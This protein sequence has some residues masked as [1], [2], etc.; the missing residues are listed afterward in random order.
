MTTVAGLQIIPVRPGQARPNPWNPNVMDAE[1][2]AK[3]LESIRQNG[4]IEPI[5]VR[6]APDGA[7]EIIDGFHRD[8]AAQEL[9]LAAIPAVN[10]GP[11][12]DQQAKKL[13]I[14]AN[15]LKGKA[16][17][18]KLAALVADLAQAE[19]FGKLAL[20]LP[21]SVAELDTLAATAQAFDWTVASGLGEAPSAAG[22]ARNASGGAGDATTRAKTGAEDRRFVL[23]GIQGAIPR[24]LA[25]Q[26]AAEYERSAAATG[27]KALEV[28]LADLVARLRKTAPVARKPPPASKAKAA[29]KAAPRAQRKGGGKTKAKEAS[30]DGAA[31]H[32]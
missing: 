4:F 11:I 5:T 31:D 32:A 28:V 14:I 25:D 29:Q 10:L 23:G 21:Y 9:A 18:A 22:P 30:G 13:T 15:E 27:S 2:Y 20:T 26:L 8:K 16:E 6:E 19:D 12:S 17:P 24:W 1:T 7:L 3:E